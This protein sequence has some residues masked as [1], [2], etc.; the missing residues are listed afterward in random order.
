MDLEGSLVDSDSFNRFN[1]TIHSSTHTHNFDPV[2][3]PTSYADCCYTVACYQDFIYH[4]CI[5]HNC[6]GL[7][8]FTPFFVL[9]MKIIYSE[10]F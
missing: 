10:I 2:H 8:D 7:I 6:K 4:Y 5:R 9:N 3:S 1:R